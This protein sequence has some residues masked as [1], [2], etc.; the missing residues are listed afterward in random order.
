MNVGISCPTGAFSSLC[1]LSAQ[2]VVSGLM[3]LLFISALI[4]AFIWLVLGG[5]KWIIS[6][7]DKANVTAAREQ[8]TQAIIGL[9]VVFLAWVLITIVAQLFGIGDVTSFSLQNL[10]LKK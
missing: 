9:A 8:V 3:S 4:I 5:I 10:F 2:S 6:G 1:N 7:G